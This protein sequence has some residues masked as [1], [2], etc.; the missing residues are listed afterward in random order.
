VNIG[1][2]SDTPNERA[3]EDYIACLRKVYAL[4][5]FV[6]AN[7]SSPNTRDLRALQQADGLDALLVS[8]T[9]ERDLL[10]KRY[11][12]RVPLAVKVAPDLDEAGIET[13][14][15]RVTARGIDAVIATNTT[16]SREGVGHL[17][18]SREQGGLSGAPLKARATAVVAKLRRALPAGV[19]IIGV[20]GVA[21]AADAREKLDAGAS[22]VQLYTA[23]VYRGP[24]LVGEIVR[25]LAATKGA[26]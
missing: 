3:L 1:K 24:T 8:L 14:A 7:I 26:R 10:A 2:N 11:G 12:N 15:D 22:L 21:S 4:A 25:G 9:A 6:T 20:G 19:T 16:V 13:I 23:L 5:S 17:P 18:A